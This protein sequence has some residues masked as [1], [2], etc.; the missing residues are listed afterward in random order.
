MP[1][2]PRAKKPTVGRQE[3]C[4]YITS[5]AFTQMPEMK[6]IALFQGKREPVLG[7]RNEIRR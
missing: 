6:V 5:R 4:H 1:G 7:S 2:I 3:G